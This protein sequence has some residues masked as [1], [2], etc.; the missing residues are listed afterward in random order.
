MAG[1]ESASSPSK[2][3]SCAVLFGLSAGTS[4]LWASPGEPHERAKAWEGGMDIG[5]GLPSTIPGVQGERI[6]DWARQSE[7]RGF[8][9]LGVLDR[10][11]Y[12]NYEPLSVLAATA[13]VTRRIR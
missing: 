12:P 7:E 9:T 11:V 4:G 8:S 13:A 3:R 10:L 5:I 2:L 6:L 1:C